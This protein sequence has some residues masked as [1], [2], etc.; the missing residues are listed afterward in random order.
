MSGAGNAVLLSA[1]SLWGPFAAGSVTIRAAK[2]PVR[3]AADSP[4]NVVS[5]RVSSLVSEHS[6]L[7][8]A[9]GALA[10][11]IAPARIEPGGTTWATINGAV[12]AQPGAY[13]AEL[14]VLSESGLAIAI[15]IR[16]EVAASWLWGAL[17]LLFGLSLL[18]LLKLLTAKATS[19]K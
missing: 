9:A 1:T 15:P 19:R 2:T 5:A 6:G 16:V 8:A 17:C 4:L 7:S 10:A 18:G 3:N 11:Q 12:P 13:L 14:D